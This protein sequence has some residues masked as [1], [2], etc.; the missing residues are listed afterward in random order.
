MYLWIVVCV[1]CL[2]K[3]FTRENG[4]NVAGGERFATKLLCTALKI[5][6]ASVYHKG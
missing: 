6:R 4:S 2:Q 3:Y 5:H 1:G